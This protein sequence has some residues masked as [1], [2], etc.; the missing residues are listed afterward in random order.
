MPNVGRGRSVVFLAACC[1][2][3]AACAGV[4]GKAASGSGGNGGTG[5]DAAV[6][7]SGSAGKNGSTGA[8]GSTS[9][10]GA[11]GSTFV[12]TDAAVCTPV[13][14]Q[15]PGGQYCGKI[16]N[17]CGFGTEDCGACP[18]G[19]TCNAGLC[20]GDS[21]CVSLAC[22]QSDGQ[23]CGSVGNGCGAAMDCGACTGTQTCNSG[24]CI[25]SGCVPL[26]CNSA[27]G[28]Y[29]GT[30][31]DG[32]GGALDCGVCSGAATCGGG[33]V[34]GVC[35]GDPSCQPIVCNPP[36]GQYCGTIGNGCGGSLNCGN[37]AGGAT[38]GG[39]GTPNVCPGS[40]GT[41]CVGLQCMVPTCTAPAT[42][43]LKGTVY[44]P[45]GVVP[46]YNV[47]VYIPNAPLDAIPEGVSCDKCNAQVS[48]R[49]IATAL[50]GTD[51][52]FTLTGVPATTNVPLVI[53]VGKWR[54]QV[55]IPSI[56]ACVPNTITDKN[57][58]RLPRSQAEGN[59][60]KI[61]VTTGGSDALECFLRE[62]G[63]ADT[64]FTTNT[65]TGRV[66]LFV[67]GEPGAGGGGQGAASFTAALGG[68]AFPAATTLWSD[69]TKLLTYDI[70]VQSC[71]GG[72]FAA[73]KQPYIANLKRYADAGGRL[74]NDHLHF[75]WLRNGPAPWPSTATY[76]GSGDNLASPVSATID[77][78]FPKGVAFNTWLSNVGATTAP[79]TIQL[80]GSQHSVT[81]PT[82]PTQQWIYVPHDAADPTM[83]Q[84]TQ[85]M[86]FNTPVE[87]TAANQCGRV[88]F[89]D[90]HVKE[91]PPP[92]GG[93]KDDSDPSKP[94]PSA[95]KVTSLSGQAKA[96]EFLFFD[97][98][99]CVQPD[100]SMPQPPI[101][102]PP[103]A[104]TAPPASV[105][106]PPAAPPPPPPPPP[107]PIP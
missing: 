6:G 88:V 26:T 91:A 51:G 83:R 106:P 98:S 85:Y 28:Q 33:G 13:A 35:G 10:G 42:T 11:A 61:A 84:A 20:V 44:D 66:N 77:T 32:C 65:G 49:P 71:E 25:A 74:F 59:I 93:S 2:L 18:S 90:I 34:G 27:G 39:D 16:G 38:C 100:T 103:N 99:A 9:G 7:P 70:L 48:G 92:A 29:C 24:I 58:T 57:L 94:F 3:A 14:C 43:S 22:T 56:T 107:P 1:L 86:T 40:T 60:P 30:I 41:G 69:P 4:K 80:Y 72:Q 63:I 52:S 76:I 97:L 36:G 47:T 37:C 46:L 75:Y 89:T 21:T 54:R 64:E 68:A 79:G 31:G 101:V 102:P 67:G 82:A 81:V 19:W 5:T 96:L 15:Q 12:P 104:P 17:G 8:G 62:I 78:T 50:T 23:Y 53:Q 73:V 95:C 87:A 45:A 55:T 105:P